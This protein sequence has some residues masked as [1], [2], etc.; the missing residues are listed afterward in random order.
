[1]VSACATVRSEIAAR[2]GAV[3]AAVVV[4]VSVALELVLMP[5][6]LQTFAE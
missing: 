3:F 1:M 4:T 5:M 2:T 6:W